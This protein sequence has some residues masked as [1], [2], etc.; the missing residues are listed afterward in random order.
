MSEPGGD[1]A[2]SAL[3]RELDDPEWPR[4]HDRPALATAFDAVVTRLDRD[5]ATRRAAERDTQD[6]GEY[7]GSSEELLR[8][9]YDGPSRLRASARPRWWDRYFGYC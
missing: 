2:L 1:A 5:F 8:E 7:G 4:H 6:S 9:D 3:P